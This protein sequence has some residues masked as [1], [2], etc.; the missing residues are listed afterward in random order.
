VLVLICTVNFLVEEVIFIFREEFVG[1]LLG[2]LEVAELE[3]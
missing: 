2:F 3:A 1:I